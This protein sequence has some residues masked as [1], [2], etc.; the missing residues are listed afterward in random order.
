MYQSAL[1]KDPEPEPMKIRDVHDDLHLRAVRKAPVYLDGYP[2]SHILFS[3]DH[4]VHHDLNGPLSNFQT[5]ASRELRMMDDHQ[6]KPEPT[7]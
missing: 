7:S 4:D 3:E 1:L 2:L 6:Y 5:G